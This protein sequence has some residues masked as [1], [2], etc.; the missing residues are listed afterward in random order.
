M[1]PRSC[2]VLAGLAVMLGSVAALADDR[3]PKDL[4]LVGDHWTAWNPPT[5]FPEGAQVYIIV[6]GDTLWDLAAKNLGNP[7]LWP[8]IWEKNP[9]ILDAHW[10]YPGDPLVLGI[11][12]V[13]VEEV[14][15]GGA[16]AIAEGEG[17]EGMAGVTSAADAARA[18]QPL[19]SEDDI[20]CSGFVGEAEEALPYHVTGSEYQVLSPTLQGRGSSGRIEGL[21]GSIDTVKYNLSLGDVVYLDGGQ[22]GGL[23]PGAVLTAI[24]PGEMVRHPLS[25]AD[26]GRMHHYLGRVRVLA[27]QDQTAIA[28]IVQACGPIH[29]GAALRPFEPEPVPLARRTAARPINDPAAAAT[30]EAAPVIVTSDDG[31]FSIGQDHVVYIDRGAEDDVTPGDIF[32]IYRMNREGFPPVPIGELAV[33]SVRP[34][35]AVAKVL[36]SSVAIYLG[37]RLERK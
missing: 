28:E 24:R 37:D 31:V 16:A 8:Q 15:D 11:E 23:T 4:H 2:A 20:Y 17:D 30:L 29:V 5:E 36:D 12:A 35:T 14:A 32:T 18:P 13:P 9:Y 27:V 3:P 25:G 10:I 26:V 22:S 19:G 34:R 7:Y 1:A 21:Y 6:R 33:L